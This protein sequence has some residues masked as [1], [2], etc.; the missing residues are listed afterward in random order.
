MR[1]SFR[2]FLL[3][4][5]LLAAFLCQPCEGAEELAGKGPIVITSDMFSAEGKANI[6]VF[7]GNVVAKTGD[8]TLRSD[9]MT[10]RYSGEGRVEEIEAEGRVSL[11]KGDRVIT[12]GKAVYVEGERKITFT[13]DPRAA[14]GDNVITGSRMI[15]MIDEDRSIVEDSKVFLRQKSR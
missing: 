5:F 9:R 14:E 10:V 4:L 2:V 11:V 13:E 3:P 1:S 8:V 6:A 15:Y 12:S 7:E